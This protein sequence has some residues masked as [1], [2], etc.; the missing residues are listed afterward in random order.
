MVRHIARP[1]LETLFMKYLQLLFL[2]TLAGFSFGCTEYERFRHRHHRGAY[3]LS[4][5]EIQNLRFYVSTEVL[6]HVES[7]DGTETTSGSKTILLGQRTPGVV[8]DVGLNWI[9]VTF[10]KDA[11]ERR[12]G[13]MFF[14]ADPNALQDDAYYLASEAKQG[15]G[16]TRLLD[17][18]DKTVQ[19][20]GREFNI[21]YGSSATLLI[22]T[23]DWRE[24]VESRRLLYSNE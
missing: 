5:E 13:G 8:T 1:K 24:I 7:A 21:V 17:L 23:A 9:R 6:A 10:R 14:L 3:D 20:E 18:S 4:G 2:L 15:E 19:I 12:T 11:T 22:D 16:F